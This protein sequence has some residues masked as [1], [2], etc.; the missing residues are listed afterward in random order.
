MEAAAH[1]LFRNLLHTPGPSGYEQSMQKIFDRVLKVLEAKGYPGVRNPHWSDGEDK[2]AEGWLPERHI[3]SR[4]GELATTLRAFAGIDE[5]GRAD[6]LLWIELTLQ[7]L[8]KAE[9]QGSDP[10]PLELLAQQEL[11][12]EENG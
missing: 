12:R 5:A 1:E 2:L 11:V 4:Q 6:H 3:H 10:F 7:N 8:G 9:L